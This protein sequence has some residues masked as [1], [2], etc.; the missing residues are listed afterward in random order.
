MFWLIKQVLIELLSFSRSLVR[1]VNVSDHTKCV[2]LNNQQYMTQPMLINLHPNEYGQGLIY[3]L[4]AINLDVW[5]V[6][7]LFL[8]YPIEFVFQTKHKV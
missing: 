5:E 7:I 4:F 6:L 3:Y 1:T 2:S 8:I